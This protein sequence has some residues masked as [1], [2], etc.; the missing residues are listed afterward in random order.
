MSKEATSTEYSLTHQQF[1][2]LHQFV[3]NLPTKYGMP[4]IELLRTVKEVEVKV[5][6]PKKTAKSTP[7]KK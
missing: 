3:E 6:E 5:E 2:N 7:K 1:V 4:I